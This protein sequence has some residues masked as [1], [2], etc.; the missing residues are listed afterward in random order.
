MK[1]FLLASLLGF[2]SAE[3]DIHR[4]LQ[5]QPD[6][7]SQCA[8]AY[9]AFCDAESESEFISWGPTPDVGSLSADCPGVKELCEEVVNGNAYPEIY[10]SCVILQQVGFMTVETLASNRKHTLL[11]PNNDG[12]DRLWS[13]Q[14]DFNCANCVPSKVARTV[15]ESWIV[16]GKRLKPDDVLC[17][18]QMRVIERRCRFPRNQCKLDI[19]GDYNSYVY[20][21]GN[22]ARFKP[23]YL[24][25]NDPI[26]TCK[27]IVYVLDNAVLCK[28]PPYY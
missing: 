19:A 20:G 21:Q 4:V 2:A 17:N 9:Q 3:I 5:A 22:I 8:P 14:F 27:D 12:I 26:E 16:P 23:T 7:E 13:N 18:S 10:N 11:L 15:A 28:E 24:A 1:F 6:G 25:P